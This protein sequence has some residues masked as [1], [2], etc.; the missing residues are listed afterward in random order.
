MAA[1]NTCIRF[2]Y[3]LYHF[4]FPSYMVLATSLRQLQRTMA[5]AGLLSDEDITAAVQA[6]QGESH[7]THA[8]VQGDTHNNTR[9]YT[10]RYNSMHILERKT[11]TVKLMQSHLG[12]QYVL[13]TVGKGS[14]QVSRQPCGRRA[15]TR[16]QSVLH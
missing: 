2:I 9:T 12:C 3:S 7:S 15:V 16:Y 13:F 10:L 4:V 5:F 11:G 14:L 6:C 8:H 1:E